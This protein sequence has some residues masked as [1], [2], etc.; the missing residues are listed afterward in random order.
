MECCIH[1]E[2][3]ANVCQHHNFLFRVPLPP[4]KEVWGKI[5]FL[6][7]FVILLTGAVPGPAGGMPG[8]GRGG[9]LVSGP[10]GGSG[11]RGDPG[12]GGG[13]CSLGGGGGVAWCR[14]PSGYCCG[15]YASYWNAFLFYVCFRLVYTN[16]NH[17]CDNVFCI[18]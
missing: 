11:P 12:P 7:L 13:A 4:A 8:P 18:N 16:P 2:E 14:P 15:R 1:I 9:V 6:H 10:K 17:F 5:I 3:E